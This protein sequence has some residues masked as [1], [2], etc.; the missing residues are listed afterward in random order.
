MSLG[1]GIFE[2]KRPVVIP[3]PKTVK[4]YRD[5][6]RY[7]IDPRQQPEKRFSLLAKDAIIDRSV[8]EKVKETLFFNRRQNQEK[9]L[10]I[11]LLACPIR[12]YG[13]TLRKNTQ[14]MLEKHGYRFGGIGGFFGFT[15]TCQHVT[16]PGM[17]AALG[18]DMSRSRNI[19]LGMRYCSHERPETRKVVMLHL[20]DLGKVSSASPVTPIFI[21]IVK[22]ICL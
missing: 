4:M 2:S 9:S 14:A 7:H 3:Q 10:E 21:I 8:T 12:D 17:V 16:C 22:E 13:S 18:Q 5:L 1:R 6:G 20:S 11:G 15:F 19:V